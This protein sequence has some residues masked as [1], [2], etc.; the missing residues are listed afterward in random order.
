V[1]RERCLLGW[2]AICAQKAKGERRCPRFCFGRKA[3]SLFDALLGNAW[4]G[5]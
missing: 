2:Q 4:Q 1:L 5:R 3:V